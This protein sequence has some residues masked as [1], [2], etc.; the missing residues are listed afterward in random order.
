MSSLIALEQQVEVGDVAI[1][2][3]SF[4][5]SRARSICKV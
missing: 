1:P 4:G 5:S 2:S 3:W